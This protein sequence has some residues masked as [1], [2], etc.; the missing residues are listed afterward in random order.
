MYTGLEAFAENL[1]SHGIPETF[2]GTSHLD[3]LMNVIIIEAKFSS[4]YLLLLFPALRSTNALIGG[5]HFDNSPAQKLEGQKNILGRYIH[6]HYLLCL[7][8]FM[9]HRVW[10]SPLVESF[11]RAP[12]STVL[13]KSPR[14]SL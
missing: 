6:I 1:V 9:L 7:M 5:D 4:Y 13:S 2:P 12:Q 8:M 11:W 3:V 14:P 10:F